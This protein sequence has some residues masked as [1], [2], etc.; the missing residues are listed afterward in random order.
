[1]GLEP[2]RSKFKRKILGLP[3]AAWLIGIPAVALAVAGFIVLLNVTG[4]V[5]AD[6]GIDVSYVG[7]GALS[8]GSEG[9]GATCAGTYVG[10][11]T[12]NVTMGSLAGE[13]EVCKFIVNVRNDGLAPARL[14]SFQLTSADFAGGEIVASVEVCGDTVDPGEEKGTAFLFEAGDVQPNQTFTFVPGEDGLLWA[15]TT[16]YVPGECVQF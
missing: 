2:R 5:S 13:G 14:Q 11:D 10:P 4:T 7:S 6:N 12:I 1:M 16:H 3:V 15:A 9:T 8:S